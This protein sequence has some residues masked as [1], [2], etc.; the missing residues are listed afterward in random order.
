MNLVHRRLAPAAAAAAVV[1]ILLAGCS[2]GAD[3]S[4]AP[5]AGMPAEVAPAPGPA[6][7]QAVEDASGGAVQSETL[8]PDRSVITTG[9]VAI[10]VDDPVASAEDVADL[11]QQSGGRVD[12]RTETPGTDTQQPSAQLVLRIPSDELDGVVDRLR[13]L[14]TVTSVSMNASDVTQQRQDVEARIEALGAS[15]DRL[16]QLLSTAT[17]ITDLIAIESELTTRQAELDSLTQ[18]R[19]LL[20]DQ[21]D[22]STVT[23]ELVTEAVAPDARPDDF[24]SGVLAGWAAL[25]AFASWLGVAFG[26]MLPWVVALLVIGAIAALVIV[27]A[28]R[29]RRRTPTLPEQEPRA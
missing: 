2:M 19:D 8:V 23:V 22:F 3:E 20:V 1:A 7:D 28:T 9:W 29:G 27:L 14:G 10:T 18:Q 12:S 13:E 25:T 17:S 5:S 21:V 6:Q 24:W 11:A 16:Q 4:S 15:V 26:V